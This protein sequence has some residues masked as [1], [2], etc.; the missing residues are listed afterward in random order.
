MT[1][2]KVLEFLMVVRGEMVRLENGVEFLEV[3]PME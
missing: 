1:K 2:P 3:L